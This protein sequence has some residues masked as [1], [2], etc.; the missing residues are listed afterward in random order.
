[1]NLRPAREYFGETTPK[2]DVV[3]IQIKTEAEYSAAAKGRR[4][5]MRARQE[6]LYRMTPHDSM[7]TVSFEGDHGTNFDEA[8][9]HRQRLKKIATIATFVLIMA[10]V[11]TIG[12]LVVVA[13]LYDDR[14]EQLSHPAP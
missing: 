14:L 5:R 4:D 13:Q 3:I 7:G 1:M 10:A 2:D 11:V 9:R 6:G 8:W 12:S